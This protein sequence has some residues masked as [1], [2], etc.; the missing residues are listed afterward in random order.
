MMDQFSRTHFF[1]MMIPTAIAVLVASILWIARAE[2]FG[3]EHPDAHWLKIYASEKKYQSIALGDSRIATGISPYEFSEFSML[4]FAFTNACYSTD[5]LS[6]AEQRLLSEGP[7]RFFLI[8]LGPYNLSKKG[9]KLSGFEKRHKSGERLNPILESSLSFSFLIR[10][11]KLG[12]FQ[13]MEKN[14]PL[15]QLIYH[16]NGWIAAHNMEEGFD[17]M[18]F[19]ALLKDNEA[20]PEIVSNLIE[21][22]KKQTTA[23]VPVFFVYPPTA[24]LEIRAEVTLRNFMY[25]RI[26]ERMKEAGGVQILLPKN[27]LVGAQY[28]GVHLREENAILLSQYLNKEI[29]SYFDS[30]DS[31]DS[32]S[33]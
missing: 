28:D 29:K 17:A 22:T 4:N 24:P 23:G 20:S 10:P 3:L 27:F 11:F 19:M 1:K 31:A 2:I 6:N 30:K 18:N 32:I 21:W 16:E 14:V 8:G 5:Y 26:T 33:K 13:S 12:H 25:T 7:R 9:C 15:N